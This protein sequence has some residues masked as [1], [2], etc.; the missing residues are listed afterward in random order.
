MA[1]LATKLELKKKKKLV[2]G[3]WLK[4]KI[5]GL[6]QIM[7]I[8]FEIEILIEQVLQISDLIFSRELFGTL[9]KLISFDPLGLNGMNLTTMLQIA[10]SFKLSKLGK[11]LLG[12]PSTLHECQPQG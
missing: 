8:K 4:Q 6:F 1:F 5:S 2:S 12:P 9:T 11:L 3:I 10:T 7:K